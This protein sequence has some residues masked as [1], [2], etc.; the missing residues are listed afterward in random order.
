MLRRLRTN[1][2]LLLPLAA[3]ACIG[4]AALATETE[5][6]G[7]QVLPAPGKVVVDGKFADWDL[8][9][10]ILAC[11]DVETLRDQYSMW[12]HAM[13]DGE[14][15]YVLARWKDP[16]PLN[17]PGVKG[18]MGFQADCLQFRTLT[19][20]AAGKEKTAHWDCWKYREGGDVVSVQF[21]QR[22]NEGKI[23]DAKAEGVQQAFTVDADGKGYAQE[24]A[25]P[26]KLLT[27]DKQPLKAGGRMVMTLEPNFTAGALGRI[28]MKDIFKPGVQ[29]DRVFTF[30]GPTCWG[31]ATLEKAGKLEPR[32]VRLS[33]G[34]EFAAT[35]EAG[36]PVVNW[37]GLIQSK[38]LPGFK[39]LRFTMP[40]DGYVS[41]NL[42]APDGT[43]A[44]QL[45]TCGFFPQGAHEVKWDGLTTPYWRT[46]G[47]AVQPGDYTWKAIAHKGIGLRL[48]GWACNAGSAPWD[49]SLTSNWGGDHGVPFSAATDGEKV[50]LGWTGAEAGK[51]LVACD[52]EGNVQWK[53]THGGMGGAEVVAVDGGIVYV[54]DGGRLVYRL[55][56]KTGNY[57]SWKGKDSP[58]LPIA[59]IWAAAAQAAGPNMPDRIDGMDARGGKVF[60]SCGSPNFR[61]VDI[62]DLKVLLLRLAAGEGFHGTLFAQLHANS[63]KKIKT[64]EE[65]PTRDL[66]DLCASPH[67]LIPDIRDDI[68]NVLNGL[69]RDTSFVP[70]AGQLPAADLALSNRRHIEKTLP[71]D[72][73]PVRVDFVAVLDGATGA[74]LKLIDLEKPGFIRAVSDDLVY[75]VQDRR[76]VVALN[77]QTG[78]VKPFLTGLDG[79]GGVTADEQGRLYVSVG[80]K[81][82][83]VRIFTA[84]GKP[85][86]AIGR[87]GGRPSIGPFVRDGV[88]NPAGLV[89]DKQGK[90]WVPEANETPK[91]FSVW[92]ARAEADKQEGAFIKEFFGPTH[93]GASGG[94]INPRDPNVMAGEGCEWRIDP[95]TGRDE[96]LGTFDTHF[97]GAALYAEGSNGKLYL[98][99]IRAGNHDP[100][101][102]LAIRERLG[103]ATFA[104]R[105]TI[106][107]DPKAKTTVFWADANGDEQEQADE[108]ATHPAALTM[109]GYLGWS[110]NMNGDLTLY[111]N[112]LQFKVADFTKYNAPRYDV[113]GARQI[114]SKTDGR[115]GGMLST[116]DNRR[117]VAVDE[118]FFSCCD[119]TNGKLLWTYPNTFSGVHGSHKAPPPEVG[120]IRGAF[121]LV[122]NAVLPT[123]VGGIWAVNGNIGEWHVLTEDGFYL[124]RLFQGDGFKIQWPE[125]AVPGTILD[126]VP[127]GLG[128]EDFGGSMRQGTDG[129]VSIQAGKTALWNVE[130]TGLDAIKEIP[131]GTVTIGGA[132]V[133]TAQT[134][135]EK[136]LQAAEGNKRYM[137]KKATV[138][139]TGNLDADFKGFDAAEKPAFEKQAGSRVRVAM[140]RDDATLYVGWEVQDD[141]PWVN[142][143]DA[144]EF[145]YAR[146]D[147]VD[148]QLGTDPKADANRAEAVKGDLRL[149]IGNFRGKPTAVVYRKVADE[150]HPMTF[151]SGVIKEYPLDSVKVLADAQVAV[152]VDAPGKRYVAEAAIPLGSLG[153]KLTDGLSLRG[154]FGATH[155]DS[156]GKDT[157]LRTH[158]NNQSTGLVNDEVFELKMEPA[159]WGE[160]A[161]P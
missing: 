48:R 29:I 125:Q 145:L 140:A 72:I 61:R 7:M 114:S 122:G 130:I 112:G 129:K 54:D 17:N 62:R 81:T 77:P 83:Q 21:G 160:I 117:L 45:L 2:F 82:Q 69:L 147:T 28:T 158:W 126:N 37:N 104:L 25:V 149:S 146:G 132:D 60:I 115:P 105:G 50:Y 121:G 27:A 73:V 76:D 3:A 144:P 23:P 148:L 131:G 95:K 4:G 136:Q 56:A 6:L 65:Q 134:F 8:T 110:L 119:T 85:V 96:C 108:L 39:P 46:P 111:A 47:Q 90:L 36:R 142:G 40:F 138:A 159:N 79:V 153:L 102:R 44:R 32:P 1:F 143:A 66:N 137:V 14:N 11:S 9:G 139:F 98:V 94:A 141:S 26:W 63:K 113:T 118:K 135:R 156:S 80:G 31:Y 67:Y 20:N 133:K 13:Y 30:Q 19:T 88:L 154:D 124:T 78:S 107:A 120:L 53:H 16:T 51:A 86:G 155:G 41:L 57:V 92:Q 74:V 93:Y 109:T 84:E 59:G 91:R 97:D 33:D 89:V 35:M 151:S 38:E 116:P 127:P 71:E 152:K 18:D 68:V 22:F 58:D 42:F 52:L 161:F 103:D 12:F 70:H 34:R 43:V 101:P 49:S 128:G 106:V 10:G 75:V 15:L 150:K 99:T 87:T 24:I 100:I 55:D 64:F 157:L 123:P 5:H